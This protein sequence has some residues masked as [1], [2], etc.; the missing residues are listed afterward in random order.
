MPRVS[1][2]IVNYNGGALLRECVASL[3]A[4]TYRD[5]ETIVVD[6][7]S[8]DDSLDTARGALGNA[9]IVRLDVNAG[10]ARGN[11]LGIARAQ[12]ELV[13]TLNNDATLAPECL[14]ALVAA[15]DRH[16]DAGMFAPRILVSTD[17][18]R[19][20]STGLLVYA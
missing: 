2:V 15:A 7:G 6:N 10:F 3:A 14:A 18:Q 5:L 1:V 12:S 11:N 20:D 17:R 4:Q 19:I 13:L 16:V 8:S 9:T